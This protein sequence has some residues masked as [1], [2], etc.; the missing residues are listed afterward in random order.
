M[1]LPHGDEHLLHS[2][3]NHKVLHF[4]DSQGLDN[5]GVSEVVSI[6]SPLPSVAILENSVLSASS[7]EP[8]TVV[9]GVSVEISSSVVSTEGVLSLNIRSS[10]I[11][12][13]IVDSSSKSI[14]SEVFKSSLILS[15]TYFMLSSSSSSQSSSYSSSVTCLSVLSTGMTSSSVQ[16]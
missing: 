14:P 11:N 13:D 1:P 16:A 2:D 10:V 4:L 8:S 6:P 7:P 5:D 3:V 15:V 12:D 9:R